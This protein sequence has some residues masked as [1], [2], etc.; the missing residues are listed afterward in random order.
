MYSINDSIN[1]LAGLNNPIFFFGKFTTFVLSGTLGNTE[2]CT[3]LVIHHVRKLRMRT[4][5]LIENGHRL[6]VLPQAGIV[7]AVIGI[8]H[9]YFR[10]NDNMIMTYQD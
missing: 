9:S 4:H 1:K 8:R 5:T 10:Q 6:Q 2:R 3:Y 7:A